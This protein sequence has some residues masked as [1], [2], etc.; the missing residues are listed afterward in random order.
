MKYRVTVKPEDGEV[1]SKT[2]FNTEQE[3]DIHIAQ[4]Q[5]SADSIMKSSKHPLLI[6]VK[7]MLPL[8]DWVEVSRESIIK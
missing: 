6:I 7:E 8:D 5:E 1:L 3:A 2:T 4:L